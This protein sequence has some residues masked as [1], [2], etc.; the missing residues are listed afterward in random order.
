MNRPMEVYTEQHHLFQQ[1]CGAALNQSTKQTISRGEAQW[2][3]TA[4]GDL[5]AITNF[6]STMLTSQK[7]TKFMKSQLKAFLTPELLRKN[8]EFIF[9]LA[10]NTFEGIPN[11]FVGQKKKII[12]IYIASVTTNEKC[13]E[14][15]DDDPIPGFNH[16]RNLWDRYQTALYSNVCKLLW[17]LLPVRTKS[18]LE[19]ELENMSYHTPLRTGKRKEWVALLECA[20]KLPTLLS[21]QQA[22]DKM[23]H[24]QMRHLLKLPEITEIV[25][26][27]NTTTARK[28]REIARSFV[29]K[30]LVCFI[31]SVIEGQA[32]D[33]N[34]EIPTTEQTQQDNISRQPPGAVDVS[35]NRFAM[36]S[37]LTEPLRT[38]L[39]TP[40]ISN[41]KKTNI[42]EQC[43]QILIRAEIGKFT[44]LFNSFGPRELL[45]CFRNLGI[46]VNSHIEPSKLQELM[47]TDQNLTDLGGAI[48]ASAKYAEK[49]MT[50]IKIMIRDSV[51]SPK[52]EA[53]GR[54]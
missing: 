10:R 25:D 21:F 17:D 27:L 1:A 7:Q 53:I 44:C 45:K 39:N 32:L 8:M 40:R 31:T 54:V 47:T 11:L 20:D 30:L 19:E 2:F 52:D 28:K 36:N 16:I 33:Y 4:T 37:D 51:L 35:S 43:K 5:E 15:E 18:M 49:R 41:D 38:T 46:L 26:H 6:C 22:K 9:N 3:T 23:I 13:P 42:L 48:I 24:L 50:E 12:Q 29:K 34:P 14:P